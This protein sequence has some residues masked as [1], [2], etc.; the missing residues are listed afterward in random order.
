[1]LTQK[2]LKKLLNFLHP[3]SRKITSGTIIALLLFMAAQTAIYM[4]VSD[5]QGNIIQDND[6]AVRRVAQRLEKRLRARGMPTPSLSKIKGAVNARQSLLKKKAVVVFTNENGE[7]R[8]WDI[9]TQRYPLWIRPNFSKKVGH[10]YLDA[11]MVQNEM[12]LVL[13]GALIA[14]TNVT[15]LSYDDEG[16]I[17]RAETDGVA[18]YG[19]V[20]HMENTAKNIVNNM[21]DGNTEIIIPINRKAGEISNQTGQELGELKLLATGRSNFRGSTWSRMQNVR[22]ALNQHVN[23]VLVAPDDLFSFN[24]TLGGSV[25]TRNGWYMAKIIVNGADLELAPGGGICQASTTTYRAMLNAGFAAQDRKSH[26]LYVSYYE[27]Y[28]VGIDAT[29]FPGLQ[30]LTFVNDTGKHILIQSYTDDYDAFVNIYGTDDGR[31]VVLSGPYFQDTVPKNI[32]LDRSLSV[33]EVAWIHKIKYQD[34]TS[35]KEVV[36]SRYRVLPRY[37]VKKYT[38]LMHA[39]A[40]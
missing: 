2:P 12:E 26:S 7:E 21:N 37:I 13:S 11:Q 38:N 9:G 10:F 17:L 40:E 27:K 23:N 15:L 4:G 1:M 30:D 18:K 3:H 39:S 33:N 16:D 5:V 34:G 19:D 20:L 31:E 35:K 14:P 25:T 28:G 8:V 29:I 36:L 22:K 32:D 6:K 24:G